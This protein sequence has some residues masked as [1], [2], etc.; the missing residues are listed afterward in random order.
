VIIIG[1]T[2]DID[3]S[4]HGIDLAQTV[5]P[6]LKA[7]QPQDA[8]QDPVAAGVALPKL[9]RVYLH[10]WS[11]SYKDRIFRCATAYLCT[12]NMPAAR[13]AI[14]VLL[15]PCAHFGCRY[16]H[17]HEDLAVIIECD[18][19]LRTNIDFNKHVSLQDLNALEP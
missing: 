8:R 13:C 19:S 4:S 3:I 1:A 15:L 14:A 18:Q 10:G 9:R 6:G 11:P 16:R 2:V 12:H 7:A 5:K 17:T